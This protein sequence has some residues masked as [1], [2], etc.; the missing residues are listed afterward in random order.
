MAI[1]CPS[2]LTYAARQRLITASLPSR[3]DMLAIFHIPLSMRPIFIFCCRS[4]VK[5]LTTDGLKKI[6]LL[7][8]A[9][10]RPVA[11]ATSATWL[12]QHC[13]RPVVEEPLEVLEESVLVLV[14]EADDTVGHLAGVVQHAE[15]ATE[16]Q[17]LLRRVVL[18]ATTTTTTTSGHGNSA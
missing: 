18:R 17:R 4:Y 14:D 1:I 10:L 3:Y 13:R 7:P 9:P 2:P 16:L 15:V 12:I 6:S 8:E 11:F 5:L